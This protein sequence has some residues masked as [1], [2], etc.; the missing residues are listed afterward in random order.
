MPTSLTPI[1]K[2]QSNHVRFAIEWLVNSGIQ[3]LEA[4]PQ[5]NGGVHAWFNQ[6]TGKFSFLYSEITAYAV[7]AFLFLY[8]FTNDIRYLERA[9]SAANWLLRV[10]WRINGGVKTRL[11][12]D[13]ES[14][15]YFSH[16]TFT[17]DNWI[18]A[19]A[20]CNLYKVTGETVYLEKGNEL[21][22]FLMAQ[23]T[24]EDGLFYPIFDV[25]AQK[26][27]SPNDKWSRQSGS[28]H[29]KALFALI[30]LS[31]L[32]KNS[33]YLD[34]ASKLAKAVL[35][36]QKDDGRFITQEN[37]QTT[38][39]HPHLYTLEGL[40]YLGYKRNQPECFKA[41][42]KGLQ[43][44]FDSH[45]DR[46]SIC[47]FFQDGH[48]LPYVRVDTLAQT[49]RLGTILIGMGRSLPNLRRRLE[50]LRTQL[51]SYQIHSGPHRGG[52]L[53]GQEENGLIHRH[54]N[55]W[56]SMFAMQALLIY[57]VLNK[58]ENTYKFDFFV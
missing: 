28:F 44:I 1:L 8:Q 27:E 10:A 16:R 14:T 55:A 52:F 46:D 3:N 49:L 48:F 35:A 32:T 34:C 31:D 51:L 23:T 21:G 36:L 54:V 12:L 17:F 5:V 9:K 11:E 33:L 19:Y 24:R 41:V 38:L 42:E 47:C 4:N 45:Q 20:L 22:K 57:D 30:D 6:E 15:P 53:Y 25:E 43:W 13:D 58:Q 40:F 39:L 37:N 56:V 26:P 50:H 18:V 29:V 2:T 7:N